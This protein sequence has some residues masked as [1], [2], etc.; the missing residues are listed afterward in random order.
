MLE[1]LEE[2]EMWKWRLRCT[3][4]NSQS[5]T[6]ANREQAIVEREDWRCQMLRRLGEYW[7][8]EEMLWVIDLERRYRMNSMRETVTLRQYGNYDTI[9][10]S[11]IST[12]QM[13]E[14]SAT[15][16]HGVLSNGIATHSSCFSVELRV[17][18]Q[19]QARFHMV[20]TRMYRWISS[21]L[22]HLWSAYIRDTFRAD[23]S[24]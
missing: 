22:A 2:R 16:T 6:N 8:R 17:T 12:I 24:G 13:Y 20:C 3:F 23:V 18:H 5:G 1:D 4:W 14:E 11:Y 7:R 9:M 19:P 15:A 21:H 10:T